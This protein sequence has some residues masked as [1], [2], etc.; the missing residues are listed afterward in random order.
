[1]RDE[2]PDLAGAVSANP[3]SAPVAVTGM[4]RTGTSMIA[5]VLR[6]GGLWLG[7]DEDMIDPAPD[8]PEG[9]FEHASVVRLNEEL[10]EAT[11]G[12]WDHPPE[13][14]PLAVDDPRVASL[15]RAAREVL[16]EL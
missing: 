8:N 11:G 5:K 14:G 12:A 7:R 15:G 1:M 4:H 9:F 6:L 13:A 10:L 2:N 16:G 3:G